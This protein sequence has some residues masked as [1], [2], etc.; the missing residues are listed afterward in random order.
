MTDSLYQP[1]DRIEDLANHAEA[2]IE[3]GRRYLNFFV[4]GEFSADSIRNKPIKDKTEIAEKW[5][6]SD[7]VPSNLIINHGKYI[8]EGLDHIIYELVNKPSSNRALY[9][10]IDQDDI[11]DSGDAP[12]PSFMIFQC[13]ID[14]DILYCTAYFRA[15]E[16]ANFFRINLEE[17]RLNMC[18][19]L[20]KKSVSKV[21]LSVFA[22]SAYNKPDQVPLEKAQIDFMTAIDIMDLY[23][24]EPGRIPELLEMKAKVTTVIYLEGLEAI[25]GWLAPT[26]E[27]KWPT[28]L[29]VPAINTRVDDAISIGKELQL[30][31]RS[32]SHDPRVDQVSEDF[33]KAIKLIAEEFR[34]CL[35]H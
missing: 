26:R 17:M 13:A 32:N 18:E 6:A 5:R 9:S 31:R 23:D 34:L 27:A 35:Q 2:S 19:I 12:I 3:Q 28:L 29:N 25:K 20:N 14:S 21:R 16:I 33:V 4:S 30:L 15:L 8:G 1:F 24:S 7:E 22:F 11:L 10:L